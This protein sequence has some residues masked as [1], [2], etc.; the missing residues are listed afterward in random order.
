MIQRLTKNLSR[1]L[2][3]S[4]AS[5]E[6]I[7]ITYAG[8]YCLLSI[9]D[10]LLLTRTVAG[11]VGSDDLMIDLTASDMTM[12]EL[13]AAIDGLPNYTAVLVSAELADFLAFGLVS[14]TYNI[15]GGDRLAFL[16][17]LTG[18]ELMTY[19]RALKEQRQRLS[20][21]E[22]QLYMDTASG[23][24]LD[25][26][27]QTFFGVRRYNAETDDEYSIRASAEMIKVTQ[28]NQALAAIVTNGLG[29]NCT[30][31][32]AEAYLADLSLEDQAKAPGHFILDLQIPNSKTPAEAET[33]IDRAN[34][35]VRRYKSSGTAIFT[36]LLKRWVKELEQIAFSESLSATIRASFTESLP[37]G[38]ITFGSGFRFGPDGILYDNNDPITEQAY[39]QVRAVSDQSIFSKQVVR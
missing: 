36:G 3:G 38:S 17:T 8:A 4:E 37:G 21:A 33:L 30:V 26:W 32:D 11:G 31:R 35:L 20:L 34:A 13:V 14:A 16:N 18:A 6:A 10:G 24:W 22:K 29:I 2:R 28:N 7:E 5:V 39:I 27:L 9:R 1:L 25:Y 19:G 15:V 23:E 12:A